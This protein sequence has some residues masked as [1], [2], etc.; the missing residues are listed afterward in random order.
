M[1]DSR[2]L[3][4]L[5]ESIEDDNVEAVKKLI[6]SGYDVS[7]EMEGEVTPL[8]VAASLGN[9][10]IVKMLVEAGANVDRIL[11][12][13]TNPLSCAIDNHNL[14][15]FNYLVCLVSPRIKEMIFMSSLFEAIFDGRLEIVQLLI[16]AGI[17]VDECR[18]KG[19]WHKNGRTAFILAISEGHLEIVKT[20]LEAG[21][22]P[23]LIDE[24]SNATPLMYAVRGQ[25]IDIV[26]LLIR[27]GANIDYQNTYG[28][29]ALNIAQARGNPAIVKILQDSESKDN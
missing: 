7:G 8:M 2:Y 27:S 3:E 20:L 15:V 12:D 19:V 14:N 9:L 10:E 6:A 1:N 29:T 18:E 17:N 25:N 13:G 23:N 21:A 22:D 26:Y 4:R 24:D 5:I 11:D 28:D 16:N